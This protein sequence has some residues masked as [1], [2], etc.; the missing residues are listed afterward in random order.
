MM[1]VMVMGMN[2]F[3]W[4]GGRLSALLHACTQMGSVLR[5]VELAHSRD[6]ERAF[7]HCMRPF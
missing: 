1:G 6:G 2:R 3:R 5:V 7:P 4:R